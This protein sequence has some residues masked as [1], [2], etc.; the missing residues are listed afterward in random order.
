[1]RHPNHQ[2]LSEHIAGMIA[3]DGYAMQGVLSDPTSV[4]WTYT[5]G[6]VESF[7]LPELVITNI[8]CTTAAGFIR[9]V[10]ADVRSGGTLD[11]LPPEFF[12]P[13]P[14]ARE[15]LEGELLN[16]WRLHYGKEPTGVEVMQLMVGSKFSCPACLATQVN[17]SD[18]GAS[19]APRRP[20]RATR[21]AQ[22][23]HNRGPRRH[24]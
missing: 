20:N 16:M 18:P 2:N 6:L 1:M 11:E 14:V 23:R 7:G 15:H 3:R 10:V 21:R 13:V 8:D 17:L 24:R 19:L 9:D 22:Q 4:G 5:I 12:V